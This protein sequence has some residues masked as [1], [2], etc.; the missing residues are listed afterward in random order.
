MQGKFFKIKCVKM[1]LTEKK[2]INF[3]KN[4]PAFF[5]EGNLDIIN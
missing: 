1:M 5:D 2:N 4:L 3:A